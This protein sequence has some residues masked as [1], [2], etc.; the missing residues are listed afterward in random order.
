MLLT[1][2]PFISFSCLVTLFAPFTC[3]SLPRRQPVPISPGAA[4][5]PPP[6][7]SPTLAPG[8]SPSPPVWSPPTPASTTSAP[9]WSYGYPP[10]P[11][12]TYQS[13]TSGPIAPTLLPPKSVCTPFGC[14]VFYQ[15]SNFY[16]KRCTCIFI[17]SSGL[18]YT[19]GLKPLRT[20]LASLRK[21]GC[22]WQRSHPG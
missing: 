11:T 16:S 2:G 12:T 1:H 6:Q 8:W 9:G 22:L 15:V 17:T 13:D 21:Q 14:N 18:M 19:I 5:S 20:P 10:Q 3:A 7:G 4:Y